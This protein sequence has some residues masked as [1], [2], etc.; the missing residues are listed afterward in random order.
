MIIRHNKYCYTN[1][2]NILILYLIYRTDN[3]NQKIINK[4]INITYFTCKIVIKNWR[5]ILDVLS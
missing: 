3:K 2:K 1:N 4:F 5:E